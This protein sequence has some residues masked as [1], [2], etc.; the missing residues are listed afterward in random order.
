MPPQERMRYYPAVGPA[1]PLG[2]AGRSRVTHPFAGCPLLGP[3]DLHVLSTPPAFV[4]SQDQTLQEFNKARPNWLATRYVALSPNHFLVRQCSLPGHLIVCP[5]RRVRLALPSTLNPVVKQHSQIRKTCS[6]R[7]AKHCTSSSVPR[8]VVASN[9]LAESAS[10]NSCKEASF[11]RFGDPNPSYFDPHRKGRTPQ[12]EVVS[13]RAEITLAIDP[14]PTRRM[15]P[16]SQTG[17]VASFIST[18]NSQISSMLRDGLE[19]ST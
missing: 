19:P 16:A 4:L 10:A 9:S 11:S 2:S 17:P 12:L 5:D 3:R 1:I 6:S 15:F 7:A 13:W 8:Q 14:P 18:L